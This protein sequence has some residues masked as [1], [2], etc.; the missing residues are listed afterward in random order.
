MIT[1]NIRRL[2]NRI[3]CLNPNVPQGTN[4]NYS[5]ASL[6]FINLIYLFILIH[7]SKKTTMNPNSLNMDTI[8]RD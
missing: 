2:I 7:A 3:V 5:T 1:S 4:F 6:V 8:I